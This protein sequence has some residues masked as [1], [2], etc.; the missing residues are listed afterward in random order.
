MNKRPIET[1]DFWRQWTLIA[2][3][4]V[5]AV[6]AHS[7]YLGFVMPRVSYMEGLR[8]YGWL[9]AIFDGKIGWLDTWQHG[10]HR[11]LIMQWMT[12]LQVL[13]YKDATAVTVRLTGAV[14]IATAVFWYW[15]TVRQYPN[16]ILRGWWTVV[17]FFACLM[18]I[19]PACYE[20]L[21][22][23]IGLPQIF[24]NLLICVFYWLLAKAI[25]DK[26]TLGAGL[27]LG[28]AAAF[29]V[30]FL[31]MG[32]S[33]AFVA[34]GMIVI[35]WAL[36][37]RL[38]G[39]KLA[40]TIAIP[41]LAAQFFYVVLGHGYGQIGLGAAVFPTWTEQIAFWGAGLPI[42]LG[43]VFMN[44]G[45]LEWLHLGIWVMAVAGF[46]LLSLFFLLL[47]D[48]LRGEQ[49]DYFNVA[50][51]G[52]ALMCAAS[53]AVARSVFGLAG[54]ASSRY[55]VD[56]VLLVLAILGLVMPRAVE[57][58]QSRL[59]GMKRGMLILVLLL[60]LIGQLLVWRH[61]LIAAPYRARIFEAQMEVYRRGVQN[62][63]DADLLQNPFGPATAGVNA[64]KKRGW[65]IPW[66]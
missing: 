19:S 25:R 66:L 53:V 62:Q 18:L 2:F 51:G 15:T 46:I 54:L 3:A 58:R 47:W 37:R 23:P 38:L 33:Y 13:V 5:L 12:A 26:W 24:K 50:I 31:T 48:E 44:Y 6:S 40:L 36:F 17:P 29:M 43:S 1:A 45:T 27:S 61:E 65:S 21:P 20:L 11:G 59:A 32:W 60:M 49:P 41:M 52:Y 14:L 7:L 55:Y 64:A 63:Q 35:I 8:I 56:Y 57:S 9:D 16:F 28:L 4:I 22:L 39:L 42:A 30:L 34:S 10:Q